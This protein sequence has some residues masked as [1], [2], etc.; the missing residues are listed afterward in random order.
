M[1][2]PK[3]SLEPMLG[4]LMRRPLR[5]LSDR[6]AT[7]LEAA[8]FADLRPSHLTVFQHLDAE[9]T[10]ITDLAARAQMTK[11]SMGALVND[12]EKWGYVERQPDPTDGRARIVVRTDRGWEVER[13]AR[14]SVRGFEEAWR[15]RVG[16]ERMKSFLA[17]LRQFPEEDE[18]P[19]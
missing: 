6:V 18:A 16:P 14:T 15:E 11:Q 12:L 10:R 4:A 2:R 3:P 19:R 8:G 9:G 7:D 13:M 1:E 17:V 5:A